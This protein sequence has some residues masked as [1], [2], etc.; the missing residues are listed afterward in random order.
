LPSIDVEMT[1]GLILLWTRSE[2]KG[3]PINEE[4]SRSD[5]EEGDQR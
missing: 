5:V 3:F 2:L 4:E 1:P